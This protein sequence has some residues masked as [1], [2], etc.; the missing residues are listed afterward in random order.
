MRTEAVLV[1]R[2][3]VCM[4]NPTVVEH[5]AKDH[6]RQL[7]AEA[8]GRRLI[9]ESGYRSPLRTTVGE[10]LIRAGLRLA[11]SRPHQPPGGR[12]ESSPLPYVGTSPVTP[13]TYHEPIEPPPR[14]A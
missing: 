3:D 4:M 11:P 10:L 9:A 8:A 1:A 6:Q 7:I 13:P 2:D 12:R 14:A 5:L